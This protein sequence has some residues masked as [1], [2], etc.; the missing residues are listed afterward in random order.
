MG[1]VVVDARG[2]GIGS[3]TVADAALVRGSGLDGVFGSLLEVAIFH[4]GVV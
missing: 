3:M 4:E 2:G 1:V